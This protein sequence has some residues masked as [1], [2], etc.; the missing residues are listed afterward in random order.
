[1]IEPLGGPVFPPDSREQLRVKAGEL[2]VARLARKT[3]RKEVQRNE[4]Q[5]NL[6]EGRKALA[7]VEGDIN[8]RRLKKAAQTVRAKEAAHRQAAAAAEDGDERE[9][10]EAF[11]PDRSSPVAEDDVVDLTADESDGNSD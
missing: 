10:F 7:K 6:H 1:M 4:S 3:L 8:K 9:E 2:R 11:T 5:A